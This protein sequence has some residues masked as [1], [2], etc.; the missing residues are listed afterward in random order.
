VL[1][2]GDCSTPNNDGE[3]FCSNCGAY[4]VWQRERDDAGN[5][6]P[7]NVAK[8]RTDPGQVKETVLMPKLP[9]P[10]DRAPRHPHDV[11]D[12]FRPVLR[13]PRG[14]RTT[15]GT[16]EPFPTTI[17]AQKRTDSVSAGGNH[18]EEADGTLGEVKPGRPASPVPDG[19]PPRRDV[20]AP[21]PG[22][23]VCGRCG[24]GNKPERS[25][26]RR[27]AA[28]LK[29]AAVVP[30][31]PWWR[32]L[33]SRPARKPPP[34]GTRPKRKR[35]RF[36][37]RLMAFLAVVGLAVGSAY[38]F[39]TEIADVVNWLQDNLATLNQRA[40]SITG[41]ELGTGSW[42]GHELALVPHT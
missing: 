3:S 38:F 6:G 27:C 41:A 28:S 14:T 4:L 8:P 35:R 36:P 32:R 25:F 39:R 11:G 23:L 19:A 22:E 17:T 34:A 26:C 29:E 37:L 1:I 15:T 13:T 18:P 20:I 5:K 24:A 30:T 16:Q 12:N 42:T 7:A 10:P 2:C 9:P 40:Q 33:L 21:A 31:P